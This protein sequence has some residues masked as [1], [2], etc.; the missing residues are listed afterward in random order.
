MKK[1]ILFLILLVFPLAPAQNGFNK[2]IKALFISY[3]LWKI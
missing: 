3:K 2:K 1:N